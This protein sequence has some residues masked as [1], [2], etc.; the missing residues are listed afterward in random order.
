MRVCRSISEGELKNEER[1][2]QWICKLLP[3]DG[4]KEFGRGH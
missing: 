1:N 4:R 2:D 3:D